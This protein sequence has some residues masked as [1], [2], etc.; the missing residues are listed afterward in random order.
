MCPASKCA[1]KRFVFFWRGACEVQ[2]LGL[3]DFQR[4]M[5]F[6]RYR[7]FEVA[8]YEFEGLP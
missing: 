3:L 2:N 6:G 7:G 1:F 4:M 5:D 8:V